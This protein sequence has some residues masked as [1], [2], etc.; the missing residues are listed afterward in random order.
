VESEAIVFDP[1]SGQGEEGVEEPL[2]RSNAVGGSSRVPEVV[3]V[4]ANRAGE[5]GYFLDLDGGI[6][7]VWGRSEEG[8]LGFGWVGDDAAEDDGVQGTVPARGQEI[9]LGAWACHSVLSCMFLFVD[10]HEDAVVKMRSQF[11]NW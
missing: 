8:E 10:V 3:V 6:K 5:Q 9:C 2:A 1:E 7:I 11:A 4:I